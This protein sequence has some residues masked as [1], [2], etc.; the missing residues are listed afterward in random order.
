MVS[1]G[2]A[3][4]EAFDRLRASKRLK[5]I[6]RADLLIADLTLAARATLVTRNRKDFGRVPGLMTENWA[7]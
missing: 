1:I 6:G 5:S 4:A 2:P 7:D 3:A